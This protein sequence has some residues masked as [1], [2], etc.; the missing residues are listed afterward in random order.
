MMKQKVREEGS[1][2]PEGPTC[3]RELRRESAVH[4]WTREK[5]RVETLAGVRL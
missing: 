5:L 3:R 2:P 1:F 4:L